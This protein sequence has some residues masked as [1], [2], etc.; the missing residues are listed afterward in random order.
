M[1]ARI[2][3]PVVASIAL[4]AGAALAAS[5][6]SPATGDIGKRPQYAAADMAAQKCTKLEQ[7]TATAIKEKASAKKIAAAKKMYEDGSK[8][9]AA[10][11]QAEGVKKLEQ[12]LRDLGVKPKT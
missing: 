8:L 12:A 4:L 5:P 2:A 10:N 3:V 6:S 9:C 11:K 1:L 7:Q